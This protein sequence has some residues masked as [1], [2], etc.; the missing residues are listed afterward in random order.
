MLLI[1]CPHSYGT[2]L[3]KFNRHIRVERNYST[4]QGGLETSSTCSY[5]SNLGICNHV[6]YIYGGENREL[7]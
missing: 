5:G 7:N 6:L 2:N 3:I 4:T 1:S